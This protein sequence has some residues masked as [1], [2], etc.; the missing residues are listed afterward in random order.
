MC[1][2]FPLV[3]AIVVSWNVF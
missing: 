3:K 2:A 1:C